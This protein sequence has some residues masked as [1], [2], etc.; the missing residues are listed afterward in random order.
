MPAYKDEKRGTW[1]VQCRIKTWDNKTKSTTKRGFKTKREALQWEREFLLKQAGSNEMLFSDFVEVYKNDRLP[2]LKESTAEIKLSIIE[3]RILPY[4]KDKPLNEITST[5]VLQW[6]NVLLNYKN[7]VTNKPFSKSYLKTVHNQLTAIFN[8]A[9]RFYN[10][11]TNPARIVGNMGS[12][13]EI[14]MK[15]WTL[16]EYKRFSEVMMDKPVAYY[17][18]QVLYWCGLRLGEMLALTP[19]DIDFE[20][21]TISVSK[22]YWRRKGADHVTPPKTPKSV[23]TITMPDFLCEELKEYLNTCYDMDPGDRMF[24]ITKNHIER[25]MDRGSTGANLEK[26]RVHDLR[27]SHVSLLINMGYSAVAI[28]DR[29]GHESIDIT[30]RYAHLFP[31]VQAEMA[32]KLNQ[33]MEVEE[34]D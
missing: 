2:R 34:D 15:F 1:F 12:E 24:P 29:M 16:E 20:K 28:A 33:L 8:H 11:P 10:L 30:Y 25:E 5:D 9:V 22:T 21:K 18:F 6:Q 27:H 14:Q 17:A 23:R 26:I 3:K 4:F 13:K 19:D 31:S 32:D 7:E